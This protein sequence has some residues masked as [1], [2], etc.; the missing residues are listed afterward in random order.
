MIEIVV[1]QNKLEGHVNLIGEAGETFDAEEGHRRLLNRSRRRDLRPDPALPQDTRLW[2][3]LQNASGGIWGGCVY[4]AEAI[5]VQIKR[6]FRLL[7]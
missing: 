3:I 6:Q 7:L 1:D 2:A 5:I 4:D